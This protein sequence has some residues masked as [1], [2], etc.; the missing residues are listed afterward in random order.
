MVSP[1][2]R[3]PA[4]AL[5][6]I[7]AAA[8][9]A[10]SGCHDAAQVTLV[11]LG[12]A[13]PDRATAI[14]VTAY[15]A[16][17]ERSQ[18]ITLDEAVAI[19]S[20]PADTEQLG[21][22]VQIGGGDIGA[23]GKSAPLAYADLA[24]GARIPVFM[25]PPGG[26]CLT[27]AMT[28]PRQQPLIARA[29]AG[30][31]VVGG[32]GAA[33]ALST[34]EYYDPAT[35]AFFPVAVPHVL[36]ETGF[37]G[38]SLATLPDGRVALSG[39]SAFVVFDPARRAFTDGPRLIDPYVQHASIA[40]DA[41]HVL[42]AGGC[43]P[44][45]GGGCTARRQLVRYQVS[46][47]NTPDL[48]LPAIADPAARLGGALFDVGEQADGQRRFVFAGG[49][50]AEL[51]E[52]FALGDALTTP[53]AGGHGQA[54]ALDGGAVLTAFAD[55][56][57]PATGAASIASPGVVHVAG[58]APARTGARLVALE[59]GQVVAIG[60]GDAALIYDPTRDR[61]AA[62]A[63]GPVLS[64]PAAIRLDDGAVLV[65]GGALAADAWL[66]RPSLVG[67]AS[68]SVTAVPISGL[69]G[70]VL[71][72]PDPST[73]TRGEA[74]V[75]WQLI[76]PAGEAETALTA[77]ALVG[78]PRTP[79][80]SIG[81]VAH[82]AE[83]GAALLARQIAPGHLMF[84]ELVPGQAARLVERAGGADRVVCTGEVAPAFDPVLA[85]TLRLAIS[86]HDAAVAVDDR[87]V[88]ACSI[89]APPADGSAR[90]AWG[91]ASRPVDGAGVL[92]VDSV[93]VAR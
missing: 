58:A 69:G 10:T 17:G 50:S 16:A 53:L 67:P 52:S 26:W 22:E 30:V 48:A 88:L 54:A 84:A 42:F 3:P 8:G 83:G 64:S 80:G 4:F 40:L 6:A 81:V 79:T 89:P 87:P 20:F 72:A 21:V 25:A 43:A 29:G 36:A 56:R 9:C 28:E 34:A 70:G 15:T 31:L 44:T 51:V 47:L 57:E 41:D 7:C 2:M 24:D 68:G 38:F 92:A 73:V 49:S 85:V 77:R 74:P 45:A 19:D 66:Y 61:W 91:I 5:A 27:G 93:T 11:P 78:G 90:G 46:D 12:C 37:A 33:G 39:D 75:A 59:D 18:S 35:A 23:A 60:G 65:V 62:G 55:D 82:V 86:D 32:T 63:P 76:A 1:G 71:T 13:R 14:K